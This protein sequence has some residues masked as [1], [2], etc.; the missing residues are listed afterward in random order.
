MSSILKFVNHKTHFVVQG[1]RHQA[2]IQ[3]PLWGLSLVTVLR[4]YLQEDRDMLICAPIPALW[5]WKQDIVS[6]RPVCG[7]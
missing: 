5:T 1:D 2:L 6:S 3:Y 7:T 4:K